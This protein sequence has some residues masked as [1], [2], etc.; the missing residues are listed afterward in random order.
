VQGLRRRRTDEGGE[1]AR[2]RDRGVPDR[3]PVDDRGT[4]PLM[5][6]PDGFKRYERRTAPARASTA[7][8]LRARAESLA[9]VQVAEPCLEPINAQVA[10]LAVSDTGLVQRVRD[11]VQWEDVAA[12]S[13][14]S[15]SGSGVKKHMP[16]MAH[17]KT[18]VAD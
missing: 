2:H 14:A 16:C 9:V 6:K 13:R 17:L 7:R 8:R 15:I 1:A 18:P 11:L 12:T 10:A 4:V 5:V 3:P